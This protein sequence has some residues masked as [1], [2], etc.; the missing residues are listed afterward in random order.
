MGD[1]LTKLVERISAYEFLNSIIPGAVYC[2]LVDR[3][4]S[5][6][7]LSSNFFVNL[8]LFYFVGT[9]INRIGSFLVG[10]VIGRR[11]KEKLAP[12]EEYVAAE[13]KQ[14]R[15]RGLMTI[16]NMYRSF[17]AVAVC[18]LLTKSLSWLWPSIS[19]EWI[20]RAIIVVGCIGIIVLFGAAY[21]RQTGFVTKR[22]KAV[23]KLSKETKIIVNENKVEGK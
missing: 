16:R 10:F 23:N 17:A 1:A 12:Y 3:L 20:K 21:V 19:N 6:T 2:V 14:G 11:I 15:V 7:T 4:T 18:I 22:V 13:A 9:I 8:I 5:F